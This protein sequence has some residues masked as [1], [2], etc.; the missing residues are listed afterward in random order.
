MKYK[1]AFL[2]NPPVG[3]YQR[4]EDRSQGVI[5]SSSATSLRAPI[6]LAYTAA[7]VRRIGCEPVIHDYPAESMTWDD[8]ERDLAAFGPDVA[9]MS[10]TTATLERDMEAFE[11]IKTK[12]PHILTIAKGAHFFE[13]DLKTLD[14]FVH[15]DYAIRGEADVII[16]KLL[17]A[18]DEKREPSEVLGVIYRNGSGE[19]AQTD[20]DPFFDELDT[21]PFPARDLLKNELYVRPDTGEPQ[22]TIQTARGCPASCVFC[23]TPTISGKAV[24]NRSPENIVDEIEECVKVHGLRNFFFRADTFTIDKKWV[25]ALCD[26]IVARKL[27]IQWVANSRVDTMSEDRAQWMKRAGCWLVAFGIEAGNEEIQRKIRKGATKDQA[28]N[29]VRACHKAGLK[30]YGFYLIGFPWETR[31]EIQETLDLA[32][33]LSCNFSEVHIAIPY[34]GT[35]LHSIASEMGLLDEHAVMGHNY[36]DSPP[37]DTVHVPREEIMKMRIQGLKSIYLSPRYI[38]RTLSGIR[39]FTELKNYTRYGMRL[40]KNLRA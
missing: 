29:A 24:R 28:R 35:P 32:R 7:T 9:I 6:D 20:H 2:F 27:D 11:R 37:V 12:Y 3:L 33:E 10:I 21:M 39:S 13:V 1:K 34:E 38:F 18:L 17:T 15:V 19:W 40:L 36:F 22:V 5:D 30:T 14:L 8:F 4:G 31:E 26:E 16:P 23:L 25:K